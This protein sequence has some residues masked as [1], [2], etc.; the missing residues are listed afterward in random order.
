ME[1]EQVQKTVIP[2]ESVID[3]SQQDMTRPVDTKPEVLSP[4]S[5]NKV[6]SEDTREDTSFSTFA[7]PARPITTGAPVQAISPA[8]PANTDKPVEGEKAT[9]IRD[10]WTKRWFDNAS[11]FLHIGV[12]DFK[13]IP[14]NAQLMSW[15]PNGENVQQNGMTFGEVFRSCLIPCYKVCDIL[16]GKVR[17]SGYVSSLL[18]FTRAIDPNQEDQPK[19]QEHYLRD[20]ARGIRFLNDNNTK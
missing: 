7:G 16:S 20:I 17:E 1:T 12:L 10:G 6:T 3:L 8:S 2:N 5:T 11:K 19:S 14:E 4:A 13:I 9:I 18:W 15:I